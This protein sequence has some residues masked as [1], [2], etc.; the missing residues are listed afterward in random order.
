MV[1]LG[2]VSLGACLGY[3]TIALPQLKNETNTAVN[4]DDYEGSM[5]ASGFWFSGIICSPLG[6]VLSGWLG[7]RKILVCASPFMTL[8]WL[9]IG[10]AQDKAMIFSGRILTASAVCLQLSS[11]NVYIS[12]TVHPKI[13]ANLVIL[14]AFFMGFGNLLVWAL[15]YFLPWRAT[16]YLLMVPPI[17]LIILMIPLP[18]TP[19]WLVED[20]QNEAAKKSLQF[21]RGKDYDIYEELTE[22]EVKHESKQTAQAQS[23]WKFTI[24]RIF[25]IAFF[26]PFSCVGI[27]YIIGTWT[28]FNCLLVYMITFLEETGSSFDPRIGPI[29]V[30]GLRVAFAGFATLLVNKFQPKV[31][32]VTCQFISTA[33]MCLI[34]FF[35]Y[36]QEFHPDLPYL[37]EFSW[38]PLIMVIT[39]VIMRS[40]GILPILHTLMAEVYP[41]EIRTQAIGITQAC[42]LASG[43]FGVKFFPEMKLGMGLYGLCFLYT[44]FGILNCL[45]GI[46]TIPDNRGKSLVKVEEMYEQKK[47]PEKDVTAL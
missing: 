32:Y 41:T 3:P 30:G 24:S 13:R 5:F 37:K 35:A 8:G 34:G 10:I 18:E 29:V 12:E 47:N 36:F 31:L 1:C 23:N 21:F 45:W 7:R 4:L 44:G 27:L 43:A 38:V 9:I 2:Y 19:Y 40:S 28:G 20:K 25:S 6:G 33:S 11:V 39:V 17:L 46:Y 26:K 15:G 22:I 42:F 16:A 14:P